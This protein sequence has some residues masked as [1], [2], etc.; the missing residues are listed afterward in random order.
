MCVC[1][2]YQ[3]KKIFCFFKASNEALCS[4]SFIVGEFLIDFTL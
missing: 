2:N 4:S 3:S 1:V